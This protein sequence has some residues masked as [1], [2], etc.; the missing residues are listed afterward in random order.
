MI[1]RCFYLALLIA[2]CCLLAPPAPTFCSG[3]ANAHKWHHWLTEQDIAEIEEALKGVEARG[4]KIE[5]G[6]KRLAWGSC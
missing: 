3:E 4:L 1:S 5:V 6:V 2:T